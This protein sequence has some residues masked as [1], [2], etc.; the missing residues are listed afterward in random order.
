[1]ILNVESFPEQALRDKLGRCKAWPITGSKLDIENKQFVFEVAVNATDTTTKYIS[2][3]EA[4]SMVG[5]ESFEFTQNL[6]TVIPVIDKKQLELDMATMKRCQSKACK[7]T[8]E[9]E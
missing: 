9:N 7:N 4:C 3:D 2:F 8:C 5:W 1:M 6:Q